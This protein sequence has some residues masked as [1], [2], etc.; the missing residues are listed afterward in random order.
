M[1]TDDDRFCPHCDVSFD[2]HPS[3]RAEPEEW[4]CEVADA[5]ARLLDRFGAM[6]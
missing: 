2:L 6:R 5:R 1:A 3:G 4:E